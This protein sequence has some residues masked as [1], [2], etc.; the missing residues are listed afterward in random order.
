MKQFLHGSFDKANDRRV[1]KAEIRMTIFLLD[2]FLHGIGA[3]F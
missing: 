1:G 3:K 2:G